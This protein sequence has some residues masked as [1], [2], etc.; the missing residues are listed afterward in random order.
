[1]APIYDWD[2]LPYQLVRELAKLRRFESN[3]EDDIQESPT[4]LALHGV[5]VNELRIPYAEELKFSENLMSVR[6]FRIRVLNPST[7]TPL[8][9]VSVAPTYETVGIETAEVSIH[10][11]DV[12]QT[13]FDTDEYRDELKTALEKYLITVISTAKEVDNPLGQPAFW[14]HTDVFVDF[15]DFIDFPVNPVIK[16]CLDKVIDG[17]GDDM[18]EDSSAWEITTY[19][20]K[21]KVTLSAIQQLYNVLRQEA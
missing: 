19:Y 12:D 9:Y 11:F 18:L 7:R 8:S 13:I 10:L 21:S 1:M 5:G 17:G 15:G 20:K 2:N 16:I 3:I 14:K 6:G 4:A